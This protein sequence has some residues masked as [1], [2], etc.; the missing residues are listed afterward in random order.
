M[1]ETN[2]ENP[3]RPQA[4]TQPVLP[5]APPYYPPTPPPPATKGLRVPLAALALSFIFP[6]AGQMYNGQLSKAFLVLCAF[7]GSIY[8]TIEAEW[9]FAFAIFFVYFF[10]LI[11]AYRTA[12]LSNER[13]SGSARSEEPLDA[14][15]PLWGVLLIA[16]G[17]LILLHN[18]GLVRLASVGR[19]WP[20]ALVAAGGFFIY[21]AAQ[22]KKSP[23]SGGSD[24]FLS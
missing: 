14:E 3:E 5:S 23:P 6:G 10:N 1:D 22:R 17:L 4:P 19:L 11:D 7:V 12:V 9:V 18:L 8:A 2:G 24:A 20:L 16:F 13:A 15:S 21:Q